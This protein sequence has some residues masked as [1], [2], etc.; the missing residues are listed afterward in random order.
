MKTNLRMFTA[1]MVLIALLVGN[2]AFAQH[3]VLT[4]KEKLLIEKGQMKMPEASV[5]AKTFVKAPAN[6]ISLNRQVKNNNRGTAYA[7]DA[8]SNAVVSF[9]LETP[10]TFSTI[11]TLTLTGTNF[12]CAGSWADNIWYVSEYYESG[13]YTLGTIDPSSGTYAVIGGFGAGINAMAYDNSTN[14]MYGAGYDGVSNSQL[15]TINLATGAATLVGDAGAGIIIGMACNTGGTLY[16]ANLDANLY[17]INKSTGAP[18]L[19]GPMGLSI[20]YSQD[21]E[22]DNENNVLYLAG[23]TSLAS[24]YTVDPATGATT[25]VGDFPAGTEMCGFA[26]PYDAVT[27]TNDIALQSITSPSTGPNLTSTEAVT[28]R[29]KNNG[30]ASQSN[31][32]VSYT[33]NGGSAVT[34]VIAGPIAADAYVDYTFTQVADLSVVQSYVIVATATLAGDENPAN[35]SKTK[36][37][38]N[39]GNLILMQ[40][41]HFTSCSGTFYDTG[42]P[43]GTYQSS[44]NITMTIA[45]STPGAKMH[46]NFTAFEC[47][48]TYDFLKVYDGEDA[49]APMIGDFTG[50]AIPAALVDLQASAANA[51]GAITF[52]FTSDGSVVKTGWAATVS[53]YIPSAHDLAANAVTGNTTPTSGTSA[54]YLVSVTNTGTSAELGTDYTVSLYDEHDAVISSVSGVDIAVGEQ[55]TFTFAWTPSTVGVSYI[56]GKVVLTGDGNAANDQ[57]PNFNVNVQPTGLIVVT[58]GTGTELPSSPKTPFDF[59]WKNSMAESIYFA[60]EIG[61]PAGTQITQIKYHNEFTSDI[62]STPVKIFMGETNLNDLTGGWISAGNLTDVFDGTLAFPAGTNDI[63]ITLTTPYIY[64]GGNLVILSNRPMDTQYYLSTDQFYSTISTTHPARTLAVYSDGTLFDPY[65]PPTGTVTQDYF[66]NTALYMMNVE[67]IYANDFETFTAGGQVACQDPVNWTTWSNAPCGAEDAFISTDY[68]HGGVNAVKDN[69]SNDLVLLMGD[70]TSGEYKFEFWMYIPAG[71]GGYYNL[72]HD[73]A[74]STSEWGMEFYFLDAGTANLYAGGQII[75]VAYMHDQWFKVTNIIDLDNDLAEVFLD[76]VSVHSWKWSLDPL[77][78]NQG[79]NQL[80]AADFFSGLG[81]TGIAN[82]LYYIDDVVYQE[83]APDGFDATFMVSNNI[84]AVLAGAAVKI[85]KGGIVLNGVTDASGMYTFSAVPAGTYDYTI[86]LAGYVT[87]TGTF[88]GD[89]TNLNVNIT[90]LENMVLPFGLAVTNNA[91]DA[92]FTWNN[93]PTSVSVLVV[94]HDASNAVAFTDD[95]TII[96]PALDASAFIDYTYFE[97]DATTFAGPDLAT[98]QNYDVVLWFTGEAWHLGQTMIEADKA[99]IRSYV[100]GGGKFI[101]SGQDYLYDQNASGASYA[102]GSFEYDVL[103]VS[104]VTQDG[105]VIESP[106]TGT[107]SGVTGSFLAGIN[108]TVSDIYTTAKE[109]L[110]IDDITGLTSSASG[111][112]DM[113]TPTAGLGAVNTANTVFSTISLASITDQAT[114]TSILD[115]MVSNLVSGPVKSPDSFVGYNVYLDNLTIP[116]A[117]NITGTAYTFIA[118][119]PGEHVAGVSSVYTTG[120][121]VVVTL[122]WTMG[123]INIKPV[124]SDNIAIYPNPTKG[125]INIEHLSNANIYITNIVG[126]VVAAKENVSGSASFDLSGVANGIYLVKIV[127]DNKVITRKINVID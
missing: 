97:A 120:E 74:G 23:Y 73:F 66:P 63:I 60:D 104:A 105:I 41:G 86:T 95:W 40:N 117:T 44:E 55:K 94:D 49:N 123:H 14:T 39:Q 42:G 92:E 13:A 22:Y 34:E 83:A 9:D 80:S 70:K 46:F 48:N 106:A 24:L 27:Y 127:S 122:P 20:N 8:L 109:G 21:L 107:G 43:D 72:L 118:P 77:N 51:S 5:L 11:A 56:Y 102:P 98:M 31:I 99:N 38:V 32:D 28:V 87:Q 121:S 116:V 33:V 69:G 96:Q 111:L 47:E 36:T 79:M 65:A 19:V 26:I 119:A 113:L 12:I 16:A 4:E 52:N 108:F 68:A 78:G 82:P 75:P 101:L 100:D 85:K 91:I 67:P 89:A 84:P 58:I 15:Y 64:N 29:V 54:D 114:I 25:L 18:T 103:G 126:N 10:G 59:Y 35:N 81:I 17:T 71:H 1:F 93:A 30:T 61:Q 50:V 3:K 125:R 6:S 57:T 115:A 53:C 112:M 62:P 7:V 110:F 76:D 90:L 37:V 88:T 124:T 45:P 2:L